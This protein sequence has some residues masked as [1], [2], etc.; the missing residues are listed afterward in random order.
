MELNPR[1]PQLESWELLSYVKVTIYLKLIQKGST[2][3]LWKIAKYLVVATQREL[4]ATLQSHKIWRV[5]HG[6]LVALGEA[7]TV[8]R[9]LGTSGATESDIAKVFT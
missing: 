9:V 3:Q 4:A 5:T 1:S 6:N 2:D 7:R 8:N